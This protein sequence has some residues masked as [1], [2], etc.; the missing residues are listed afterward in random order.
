[1]KRSHI[2]RTTPLYL[3]CMF[4]L[5]LS[6][7]AFAADSEERS[8]KAFD[9]VS[10]SGPV[11]L[12]LNEGSREMV[13]VTTE[14]IELEKIITNVSGNKLEVKPKSGVF[15]DSAVKITVYVTYRTLREVRCT[16]SAELH[17]DAAIMGDKLVVEAS[18]S[19]LA[20]L[21]V[22]VNVISVTVTSA[23]EL[24]ISGRAQSQE[25]TVNTG[26]KMHAFEL[27]CDNA[28]VQIGSGGEAEIYASELIEGS[29]KSAGSLQ[30]KGDPKKQR[31][32][33]STGGKIKEIL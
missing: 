12:Y 4:L 10:V 13:K 6:Q 26:G 1:M 22:D 18:T 24:T 2:C 30:F 9:G 27:L 5:L 28:Y 33:K 7:A 17:S 8:V 32:E 23:G 25:I 20:K 29:V 11:K 15:T 3:L 14:G 16:T 31:V 19:G 21:K